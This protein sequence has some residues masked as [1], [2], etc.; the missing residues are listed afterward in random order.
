MKTIN[1]ITSLIYVVFYPLALY[2]FT[3]TDTISTNWGKRTGF[4]AA[5]ILSLFAA[6]FYFSLNYLLKTLKEMKSKITGNVILKGG[7]KTSLILGA[8]TIGPLTVDG[9]ATSVGE[10]L[11]HQTISNLGLEMVP[12]DLNSETD[13]SIA[14]RGFRQIDYSRAL[15]I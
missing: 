12:I 6:P 7:P 1:V 14:I 11:Q 13:P 9:Y 15:G 3:Q 8:G 5:V 10:K 4:E 2:V